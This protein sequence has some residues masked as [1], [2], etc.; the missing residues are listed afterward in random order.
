[1]TPFTPQNRSNMISWMAAECDAP[2]YG[3]MLVFNLPKDKL[4]YGP[5]QVDA[6]INQNTGISRQLTL[7]DQRG[8][9]VVR[10]KQIVTPI[11]N[12]F[13][14]V[15][16]LYLTATDMPFPQL[17]RVIAVADGR[18][19]MAPTL[20]TALGD[21]FAPQQANKATPQAATTASNESASQ[22]ALERA[23]ATLDQALKALQQGNWDAFGKAMDA[24]QH[25]LSVK[26]N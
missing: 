21:L 5:N 16:P 3:H 9:R 18:V 23:R 25:Q 8:S 15:V 17:K 13:L 19:A 4:I 10:G 1:M 2:D 7:W 22:S 6:L 24:L 20:D 26:T 11:E 14:Y 12:S